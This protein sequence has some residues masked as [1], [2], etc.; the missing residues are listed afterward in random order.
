MIED[1]KIKISML[2]VIAAIAYIAHPV[3]VLMEH[4]TLATIIAGTIGGEQLTQEL[5]VVLVILM[6]PPLVMPFLSLILKDSI[7]RWVNG[8]VGVFYALT[9]IKTVYSTLTLPSYS[10]ALLTFVAFVASVLIVWYAWK[11]KP[12]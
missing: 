3:P 9:F 6:L 7:N 4:T 12:T 2:W 10:S 11:A 1:W 5:L 8:I